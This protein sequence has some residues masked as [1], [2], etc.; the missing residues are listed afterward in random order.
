MRAALARMDMSAVSVVLRAAA[1][2]TQ[3]DLAN[4]VPGWSRTMVT[5]IE[6]GE[7]KTLSY[8]PELLAFADAVEMPREALVPLIM[9]DPNATV[10]LENVV[11]QEDGARVDRR[12]FHAT[13]FGV[14]AG[15][16]L[17]A[18][19]VTASAPERVTASHIRYLRSCID[20]LWTR[21]WSLGGAALLRQAL[22]QFGHVREMLDTSDYTEPIGRQLLAAAAELGVCGGF[23]AIDAGEQTLARRVLNEAVLLASATGDPTIST[24]AYATLA[25]QSTSLARVTGWQGLA[26]E[27]LR[28]LDQAADLARYVPASK[29]HALIWMRKATASALLDDDLAVK[30]GIAKARRALDRGRHPSDPH[31]SAF[32]APSEIDGHAARAQADQGAHELGAE[33]YRQVLTDPQLPP[34][35][36]A[37]YQAAL[38][39]TLFDAG[40]TT[41][42]LDEGLKVLPALEGSVSSVRTLHQLRPVRDTDPDGEFAGRYDTIAQ[43]LTKA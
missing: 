24:H 10:G 12:R 33:L 34:R 16:V 23:L 18:S 11:V 43:S 26:R 29:V 42:A 32:V 4:L 14:A 1:G 27:A 30:E 3:E 28:F 7:R 25:M 21:D 38:A 35:N 5:R 17:P 15:L 8:L 9:G 20:G 40:D 36:Q 31:W 13:A 22:R 6:R 2:L 19:A 41:G 37:F 39:A